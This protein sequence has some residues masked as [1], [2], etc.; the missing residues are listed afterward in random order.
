VGTYFQTIVDVECQDEAEA[1]VLGRRLL[2]LLIER[3]IVAPERTTRAHVPEDGHPPGPRFVEALEEPL[4]QPDEELIR[5]LVMNV[6]V[7]GTKRAVHHAGQFGVHLICSACGLRQDA[8]PDW[9]DAVGEWYDRRG[10]GLLM[11]P[12]CGTERG[13]TEW[14]YDP[15]YGFSALG[16]SFYNW[17]PLDPRFIEEIGAF[18]G[19][20]VLLVCGKV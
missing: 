1:R 3:G 5:S 13:V 11:C 16:V 17:P 4:A 15:P 12:Q 18:L 7:V 10:P 19:H 9:G 8:S 6:V 2:D 20:R 14:G